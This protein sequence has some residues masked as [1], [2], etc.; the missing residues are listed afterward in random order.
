MTRA[1]EGESVTL[2]LLKEKMAEFAKE[3]N[4]D[5][6][7]SPRNLLLALVCSCFCLYFSCCVTTIFF[8][9][10]CFF[11]GSAYVVLMTY[12]NL[13]VLHDPKKRHDHANGM[14]LYVFLCSFLSFFC[15]Y[16]FVFDQMNSS[17]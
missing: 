3:R 2:D 13:L 5:Q 4:W 7:H 15:L 1:T 10:S 11:L 14:N 16:L 17:F 6:F 8:M 12:M 9:V